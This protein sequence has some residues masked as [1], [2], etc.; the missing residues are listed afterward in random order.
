MRGGGWFSP[1]DLASHLDLAERTVDYDLKLGT[2]IG[3]FKHD[4]ERGRYAWIEYESGEERVR[5]LLGTW[6]LG[7][8]L[9]II[10]DAS[11]KPIEWFERYLIPFAA[12]ESGIDPQ[13]EKFRKLCFRVLGEFFKEPERFVTPELLKAARELADKRLNQCLSELEIIL[14]D[15]MSEERDRIH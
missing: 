3:I 7:F 5:G 8:I 14:K 4:E 1:K 10:F 11:L 13:D 12:A 15:E 2:H 6:A 9:N